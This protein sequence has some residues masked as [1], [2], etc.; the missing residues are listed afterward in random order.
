MTQIFPKCWGLFANKV[1]I[2]S[3]IKFMFIL[4]HGLLNSVL[5]PQRTWGF[6][7]KQ[8]FELGF[9]G[10]LPKIAPKIDL[11]FNSSNRS[12]QNGFKLFTGTCGTVW[13]SACCNAHTKFLYRLSIASLCVIHLQPILQ[14]VKVR[15]MHVL[16]IFI[17]F[18][19]VIS[20]VSF[21]PPSS[22]A[23]PVSPSGC[24]RQTACSRPTF[25]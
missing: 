12:F 18:F 23:W 19:I 21:I 14:E 7:T 13:I 8:V 25:S 4:N 24:I 11:S 22:I 6:Y 5:I 3:I 10:F 20:N 15:G 9:A 16:E 17:W 1:I 2:N